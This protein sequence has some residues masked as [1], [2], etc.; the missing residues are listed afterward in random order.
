MAMATFSET[1]Y[2]T[3]PRRETPARRGGNVRNPTRMVPVEIVE[4]GSTP[5]HERSRRGERHIAPS[6]VTAHPLQPP[7]KSATNSQTTST[8]PNIKERDHGSWLP[9]SNQDRHW[10]GRTCTWVASII[11]PIKGGTG[12]VRDP[13]FNKG[14]SHQRRHGVANRQDDEG[15][16][17]A[18]GHRQF[19]GRV[20]EKNVP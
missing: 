2:L 20:F 12:P 10:R 1:F 14:H 8:A 7:T 19:V 15:E 17:I 4:T 16:T 18:L 11:E 3:N 13:F 6:P 9:P 5:R